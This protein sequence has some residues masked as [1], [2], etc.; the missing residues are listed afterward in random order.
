MRSGSG[1]GNGRTRTASMTLKIMVPAP[2]PSA[3]VR[4]TMTLKTGFRVNVLAAVQSALM[5]DSALGD[6]IRSEPTVGKFHDPTAEVCDASIVR[7]LDHGRAV[8]VQGA[9]QLHD[10]LAL[11][12]VQ[13]ARGLVGQH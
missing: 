3:S 5:D 8:L 9:Q 10:F 6:A 1:Y 12:P 4:A 13:A 2:I 11:S 7:H